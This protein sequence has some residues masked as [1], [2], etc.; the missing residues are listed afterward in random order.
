MYLAI[1]GGRR[2]TAWPGGRATCPGCGEAVVAKCGEINAW[3]WS[4]LSGKDCDPWFEGES[5]WHIGWKRKTDPKFCEVMMGPHRADILLPSG[6]VIELQHSPLSPDH[7]RERE[8]FYQDMIWI[9][10]AREF[11]CNLKFRDRGEYWS[12]RWKWPRKW[13][14]GITKTLLWDFSPRGMFH[15]KKVNSSVPCGGWGRWI[16]PSEFLEICERNA[17]RRAGRQA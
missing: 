10:D 9:V 17:P 12:F 2:L 13:M 11:R 8:E 5:E 3:H 15:V 16:N 14:F 7:I 6:L 1:A 4:H